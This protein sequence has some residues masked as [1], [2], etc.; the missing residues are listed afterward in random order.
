[1]VAGLAVGISVKRNTREGRRG[2]AY[3]IV[4]YRANG[5]TEPGPRI[6]RRGHYRLNLPWQ[7]RQ[8]QPM[9]PSIWEAEAATTMAR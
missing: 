5:W 9:Q 1:M 7:W 3:A 4:S 8:H 6:I 2:N